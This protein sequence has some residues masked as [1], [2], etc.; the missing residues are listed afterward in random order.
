MASS[1]VSNPLATQSPSPAPAPGVLPVISIPAGTDAPTI[2]SITQEM[3]CNTDFIGHIQSAAKLETKV[4]PANTDTNFSAVT[5]TSF[6]GTVTP[7][8]SASTAAGGRFVI[9]IQT[10]G[11]VATAT[12]KSSLDGGNT[13]GALQT[14]AA[15]MTDATS[16][17]TL[18]F[19]GTFTANGT[20]AFR[21]AY[22]PQARWVDLNGNTRFQFDHNGYPMMMG[23]NQVVEPWVFTPAASGS[24]WSQTLSTGAAQAV[25]SPSAN[26]NTRYLLI[27]PSTGATST[28]YSLGFSPALFFANA[29]MNSVVLEFEFGVNAAGAGSS[30]NTS[31]FVGFDAGTTP[32]GGDNQIAMMYK[33]YLSPNY[34][35]AIGNGGSGFVQAGSSPATVPSSNPNS[36]P[37]DRFK[38][39]LSGSASPTAAYQFQMWINENPVMAPALTSALLPSTAALRLIYG[40]ANEGGAPTGSPLAYL[41]PVRLTWNY[42]LSPPSF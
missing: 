10:G 9:Q 35:V 15:S 12:F 42:M 36:I 14:T 38:I 3:K 24:I 2:E 17:L 11:A 29:A 22:T 23:I 39:E 40:S 26:Y 32:M 33:P 27:T 4:A 37:V 20:A 16:G 31:F 41:G 30:S 18:A 34:A 25:Q 1:Y 13:Y 7:T 21:G 28:S 19:A 6:G 8:G 5:Y